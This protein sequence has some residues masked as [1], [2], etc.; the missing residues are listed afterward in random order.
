MR[1]GC[2]EGETEILVPEFQTENNVHQLHESDNRRP[3]CSLDLR[4]HREARIQR[5]EE[6][7]AVG[8]REAQRGLDLIRSS[9]RLLGSRGRRGMIHGFLLYA[10]G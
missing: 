10:E 2:V 5:V 3:S 6:A 4:I 8:S 7:L 1:L 9:L